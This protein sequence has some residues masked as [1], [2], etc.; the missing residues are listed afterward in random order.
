M[1]LHEYVAMPRAAST[2]DDEALLTSAQTRARVGGVST[3]CLWRWQ[4]DER[5]QFPQPIKINNRN[6]WRVGDLRS[7]Q[8]ARSA[9]AN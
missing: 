4:R 3:M 6:Y 1:H 5:V 8:A 2:L 7:W 9:T